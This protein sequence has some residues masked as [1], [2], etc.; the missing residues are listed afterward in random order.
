[1]GGI[2]NVRRS[3]ALVGISALAFAALAGAAEPPAA[4]P[5]A[6]PMG[7]PPP[8]R[9]P[10]LD[11]AIAGVQ[12]AIAACA[13]QGLKVTAVVADSSGALKAGMVSD[14]VNAM[15]A[16]F[17]LGKIATVIDFKK[18]SSEVA[19]QA[20]ADPEFAAKLKA[21]PNYFPL[22]GA[23][24]LRVGDEIIGA[25]AV[26]GATGEQDEACAIAAAEKI[27]SQLK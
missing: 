2:M 12:A 8:A 9:G 5:P 24:P 1:M 14:G 25:I 15:T 23:V 19:A 7:P 11:V 3:I 4:P 27:K 20:K 26:S 22:P 21:N 10:S 6:A 17:A 16:R 18:P 13:A